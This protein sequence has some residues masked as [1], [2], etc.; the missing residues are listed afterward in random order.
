MVL[1][2]IEQQTVADVM[3][4]EG[5]TVV[6]ANHGNPAFSRL[7]SLQGRRLIITRKTGKLVLRLAT[8]DRLITQQAYAKKEI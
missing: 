1:T 3:A 7:T 4:E 6:E 8:A 2:D 5:F